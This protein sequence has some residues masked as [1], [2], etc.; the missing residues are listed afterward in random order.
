MCFFAYS[1]EAGLFGGESGLGLLRVL[2]ECAELVSLQS[3]N[4]FGGNAKSD[5]ALLLGFDAG[6]LG[7]TLLFRTNFVLVAECTGCHS[8]LPIG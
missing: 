2:E 1:V 8:C 4:D 5:E 6:T 7:G 3:V